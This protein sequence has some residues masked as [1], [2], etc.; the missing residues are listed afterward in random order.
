[1]WKQI[2]K[3]PFR[4]V[5]ISYFKWPQ[6]S[7][8]LHDDFS[9]TDH[10][11]GFVFGGKKNELLAFGRR[12]HSEDVGNDFLLRRWPTEEPQHFLDKSSL[13]PWW[14]IFPVEHGR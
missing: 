9:L 2:D 4:D 11:A 5:A 1:M 12:S 14:G 10:H 13:G 7:R 8:R 6:V 3:S